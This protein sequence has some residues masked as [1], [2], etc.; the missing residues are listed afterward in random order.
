MF[1]L[2]RL[3]MLVLNLEPQDWSF[4]L[5]GD[6]KLLFYSWMLLGTFCVLNGLQLMYFPPLGLS[7]PRV[8]WYVVIASQTAWFPVCVE[9]HLTRQTQNYS[10]SFMWSFRNPL[11]FISRFSVLTESGEYGFLVFPIAD[12]NWVISSCCWF[13]CKGNLD[14]RSCSPFLDKWGFGSLQEA[15]GNLLMCW[16][17][18]DIIKDLVAILNFWCVIKTGSIINPIHHKNKAYVIHIHAQYVF[19]DLF[20]CW[21]CS[22]MNSLWMWG[23]IDYTEFYK[24]QLPQDRA[25]SCP[26]TR[27][28]ING[29][30][31]SLHVLD[32]IHHDVWSPSRC[33]NCGLAPGEV[34]WSIESGRSSVPVVSP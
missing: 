27:Q 34:G 25:S 22:P 7:I 31:G 6:T 4:C 1:T 30:T 3:N 5:L 23:M 28:S 12:F 19:L 8:W 26:N 29:A 14:K 16:Y 24:V 11:I 33:P 17:L 15:R 9:N 13:T 10:K 21:F 20:C 2:T 32:I 18:T